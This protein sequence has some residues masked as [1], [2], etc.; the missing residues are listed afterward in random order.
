MIRILLT[1]LLASTAL[2]RSLAPAITPRTT[3][4]AGAI[5]AL[6]T[7]PAGVFFNPAGL[8]AMTIS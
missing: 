4:M 3:A 8:A 2:A 1:I 5:V 6:P 7:D